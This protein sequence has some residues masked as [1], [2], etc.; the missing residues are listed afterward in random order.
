MDDAQLLSQP[1]TEAL[2]R[3]WSVLT[4]NQRA[5]RT[6]RRDFDLRQRALGHVFWEPP[7]ILAWDSWLESLWTRLLLDGRASELLLNSSQEH[8][9]WHSIIQ[10]DAATS[11]LRPID[12]LAE[13]AASAWQLLHAYRGRRRLNA[14]AGNTDTRTFL[15]WAAE[16]ERRCARS[17]YLTRAQLPATL[18]AAIAAG[19]V[20][21]PLGVL[22]VGFDAKTPAQ[23]ALLDGIRAAGA[24]VDELRL[25]PDLFQPRPRGSRIAAP[26]DQ[27]ELSSCA[28]WLRTLLIAQPSA[29]VAVIVPSLED[30]R[31]EIDR[32]FRH[33]LAPELQDIAAPANA[34]PYEFSLGVPLAQTPMVA[35]ALDT[36]RWVIGPLPLERVC[37]LLL[38]PYFAANGD[39]SELLVRAEFDAFALRLQTRLQPQISLDALYRLASQSKLA[40]ALPLLLT[41]LRHLRTSLT[42]QDFAD[43]NR[44]RTHADWA[45]TIQEL[46]DAAGWAATTQLDSIEFQTRRK[47]E[48]ALDELAML[49]FDSVRV[50]FAAALPALE[51]I[52]N[53]TLFAPES[54]HAPIQIMGPLESAGSSFDAIWFLS[55]NDLAWPS[56]SAPH[57]LLPWPLQHDLAMPGTDPAR[58]T[59]Y[60]RRV[61]ERIA[62]SAPTVVFSYAQQSADGRQRPSPVLAG[63]SLDLADASS[64]AGSE[65]VPTPIALDAFTES[66][67]APPPPGAILRGGAAILE[68]QAR[69]GFRA[70]AEKRLFSSAPK[71]AVLGLEPGERGSLV[72]AVLE[73]FWARVETQAALKQ[74]P[75]A[76]R[77][78][79]LTESIHAA[80]DSTHLRPESGWPRAYISTER[81]RLLNLLRPWLDYE[82]NQR[83]PFI[84]KSR[85]ATQKNIE[86]GNLH[87]NI[88]VDRVDLMQ[89][90][91]QTGQPAGEIIL[92][93]K[94]G[95]A[96]PADWVG[97]RPDAPQLPLYA[98]VS[99]IPHL[100]A[101]AFASIRPGKDMGLQGYQERSGI[102]P[103]ARK[104]E[105]KPLDAQ[106]NE[107][108]EV[109]S[110]LA[111]D[112]YSGVA[113]VAPKTYPR[114]CQYC[115][116]RLLCRLDLS[117]LEADAIEELAIDG[118]VAVEGDLAEEAQ[119][120]ERG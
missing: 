14:Y 35:C 74:M 87:L 40:S 8:T 76:E 53:Q 91:A 60:A 46:L 4:A 63:L 6:L 65:F 103:G 92:D 42:K 56:S 48:S 47:W 94:T 13:L 108:R 96:K 3:G 107:W 67:P 80:L 104:Q 1:V 100:S 101:L 11:S 61:T 39:S 55:A 98:V 25:E 38:S 97:P 90:D 32:V 71:S 45:A 51:R 95:P 77:D 111:R 58:D 36:L 16:L 12:A 62:L 120:A 109:L 99:D 85:E 29:R 84:V 75:H 24:I 44:S 86:I 112:F 21:T 93:Y 15:R 72:H 23:S 113:S 88:R 41:H 31:A 30:T 69:C 118:D 49:D 10:S 66:A 73:R 5:A 33:I 28:R 68:A 102:I 83:P 50:P 17:H 20:S 81:Q 114:T 19:H 37:A 70:F 43:S 82:A 22:L 2:D 59:A 18:K 9:L 52:A 106:V 78:T 105:T 27:A 119:E 117:T 54:R 64:F 115:E 89:E 7:A 57:P 110:A 116:Q 34:G 79:L 26:D